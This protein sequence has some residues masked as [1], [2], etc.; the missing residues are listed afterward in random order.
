MKRTIILL[1]CL[2]TATIAFA[3][4]DTTAV[5]A[6]YLQQASTYNRMAKSIK[7]SLYSSNDSIRVQVFDDYAGA[8]VSLNLGLNAAGKTYVRNL[9]NTYMALAKTYSDSA[10][11][12]AK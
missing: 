7:A 9:Y 4:T 1:Y 5:R 3:Q 11:G 10:S 8:G 12:A 2:F 6:G